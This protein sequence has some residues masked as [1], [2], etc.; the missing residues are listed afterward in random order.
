MQLTYANSYVHQFNA[1]VQQDVGFNTVVTVAYV[2]ELGHG[3]RTSP[4]VN[5]GPLGL[6][7]AGAYTT[8]RPFYKQFPNVTDISIIQ[9]NGFSNYNSLQ[10]TVVK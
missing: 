6:T 9:S 3:L 10:T 4:N 7:T 5:L 8:L 2:G 1:N